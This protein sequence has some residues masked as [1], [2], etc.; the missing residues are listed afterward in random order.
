MSFIY[1][2]VAL[3]IDRLAARV[4]RRACARVFLGGG[5]GGANVLRCISVQY[6]AC[7]ETIVLL[8]YLDQMAS[9]LI[10]DQD[11]QCFP[12]N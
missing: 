10:S 7:F 11:P 5:G 9:K 12:L 4:C 6:F 1:Y 3:K 8:N 2:R